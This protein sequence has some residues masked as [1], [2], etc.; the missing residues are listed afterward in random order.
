VSE[1]LH[2][3]KTQ[4]R[5]PPAEPMPGSTPEARARKKLRTLWQSGDLFHVC[6]RYSRRRDVPKV[7]RLAGILKRG[8]VAPAGCEDG[9]VFSD[10]HILV[11]GVAVPYDSLVFLHRFGRRSYLYTICEPG[12]FAV[13]VDP[14]IPVLTPAKMGRNWVVLCQDEVYVRDG[15]PLERLLAVAVHPAD[16][17]VI[18]KELIADFQRAEIPLYDY[19]GNVLWPPLE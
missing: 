17:A 15:I 1:K 6:A 19:D 8:L 9:S 3:G 18:K 14:K 16:G 13:F 2:G 11:T 4:R 12:R 5:R 7:D 10:L